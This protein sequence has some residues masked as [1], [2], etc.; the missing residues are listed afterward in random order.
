MVVTV[1]ASGEMRCEVREQR[2][3]SPMT[4]SQPCEVIES[5]M[6]PSLSER[7]KVE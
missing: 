6:L 2:I 7:A 5:S 3:K 4:S 1:D